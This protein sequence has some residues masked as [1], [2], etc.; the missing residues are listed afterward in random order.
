MTNSRR[1]GNRAEN[2]IVNAFKKWWGG[3]WQRRSMGMIGDDI[4]SP[5][6]FPLSLEV[7]NVATVKTRH[8]LTPTAQVLGFWQQCKDQAAKA[9]KYPLLCIKVESSWYTVIK[10]TAGRLRVVL[11]R[12]SNTASIQATWADDTVLILPLEGFFSFYDSTDTG[13]TRTPA[14]SSGAQGDDSTVR[15]TPAAV[16]E[17]VSRTKR[18]RSAR[19][20]S[21]RIHGEGKAS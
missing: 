10:L 21:G 18:P 6:S 2:E 13:R 1:K 15:I 9:Y 5:P 17:V 12:Q 11:P 14:V 3:S 7:K 20:T 8:L 16:P 19:T 4:I